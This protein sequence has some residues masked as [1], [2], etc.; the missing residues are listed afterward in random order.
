MYTRTLESNR[1]SIKTEATIVLS[2]VLLHMFVCTVYHLISI[3]SSANVQNL[4]AHI[5]YAINA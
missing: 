1:A 2:H 5:Q 4:S 3:G